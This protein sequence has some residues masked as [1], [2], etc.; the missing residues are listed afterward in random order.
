MNT[1]DLLS[2][3]PPSLRDIWIDHLLLA[4]NNAVLA[5][6]SS[7]DSLR[8]FDPTT[9]QLVASI[10][11][12]H[13]GVSCLKPFDADQACVLTAGRGDA[14]VRC[15][16]LRTGKAGLQLGNGTSPKSHLSWWSGIGKALLDPHRNQNPLYFS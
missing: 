9:L 10:D 16:D 5:S 2:I 8:T 14:M 15:W 12:I 11:G 3:S 1:A 7:D 6:T 4:S 13:D